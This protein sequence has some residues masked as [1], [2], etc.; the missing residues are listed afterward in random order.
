VFCLTEHNWVILGERR[1]QS[2]SWRAIR[3]VYTDLIG[4]NSDLSPLPH[5]AEDL[6]KLYALRFDG[7]A[8]YRNRVW[9]ELCAYFARWIPSGATVLD[10]GCGHCEFINRVECRRKFGMD[11]NPDA[12]AFAASQVT[13]IGQDCS[14]EWKLVPGSIDVVFTSNFFEHLP[15]KTALERTL[16]RAYDAL[17]PG[18]RIIA[19]GPNVKYLPGEYWDFLDHYLPLTELSLSEI[20]T[21]CGFRIELCQNRFLPYTMSRGKE[22]PIWMLRL[23]LALPIAWRLFG[24]QFLL[25]ASKPPAL[26]STDR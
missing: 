2:K 15:S 6:K 26:I 12:A 17:T 16:Q 10:L 8:S 22:Y 24:K 19:L 11:L 1:S 20:L 9:V 25:V 4:E 21:K 18:G 5:S 23:Y 7:K 3:C 14:D 13:V